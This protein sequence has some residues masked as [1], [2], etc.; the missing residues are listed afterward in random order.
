VSPF[1]FP[2]HDNIKL[3]NRTDY[4]TKHEISESH[5]LYFV[6]LRFSDFRSLGFSLRCRKKFHHL[7][8]EDSELYL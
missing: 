6:P 4:R 8:K 3:V 7:I 5:Q 1:P 2:K